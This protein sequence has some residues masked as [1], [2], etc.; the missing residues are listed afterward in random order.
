MGDSAAAK[1]NQVIDTVKAGV[2]KVKEA[3]KH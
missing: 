1:A 2:E 3:V